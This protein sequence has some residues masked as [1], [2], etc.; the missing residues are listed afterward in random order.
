MNA[1]ATSNRY[2]ED[3]GSAIEI[4]GRSYVSLEP[5]T[6]IQQPRIRPRIVLSAQNQRTVC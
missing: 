6:A 5:T 4:I 1:R 2:F 3:I